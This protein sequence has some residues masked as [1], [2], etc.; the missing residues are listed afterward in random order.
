MNTAHEELERIARAGAGHFAQSALASGHADVT[1]R[2]RR[3]RTAR[4]A[5]TTVAGIGVIGGATWG[6]LAA[7]G[8]GNALA[9]GGTLASPATTSESPSPS[10]APARIEDAVTVPSAHTLDFVSTKLSEAYGVSQ[11]DALAAITASV[12]ELAPEASTPE[13]W[14]MPGTFDLT[15]APTVRDAADLMVSARVKEF[16]DLGVPRADWQTVITKASL[17][18]REAKLDVDRPK[19]ARVIDNRLAKGMKLELDST[20]KY[21]SP[22]EGVFTTDADRAI[23]SPYNTYLYQGLP[24]GAIAAP[25]DASIRAVLNPAE[26]D[27]LFFVTVNLDTGETA[28]A[29]T[30]AE[31]QANVQKLQQWVSEHAASVPPDP[32]N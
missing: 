21:I 9:P 2:V 22:V 18:E 3:H 1:R 14:P 15:V 12:R 23:D 10:P 24:P 16:T 32:G 31:H 17:V 5:A 20:V 8:Q 19:I 4:A 13:G 28:Y 30:F 27:W 7:F 25:S 29:T 6:G 26:G 11:D